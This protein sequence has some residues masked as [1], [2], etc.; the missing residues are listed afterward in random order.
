MPGPTIRS[1]LRG[2]SW[3]LR[4]VFVGVLRKWLV[5]QAVTAATHAGH[6]DHVLPIVVALAKA[7][8]CSQR[9]FDNVPFAV[10]R[11]RA[12]LV[13]RQSLSPSV[14]LN[15]RLDDVIFSAG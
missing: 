1:P 5:I 13:D 7:F 11:C 9:V 14:D 6:V 15:E 4:W 12:Q 10:F 3:V 2:S 8:Q